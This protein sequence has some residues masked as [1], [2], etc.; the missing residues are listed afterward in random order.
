[1]N[2]EPLWLR[3]QGKAVRELLAHRLSPRSSQEAKTEW[4]EIVEGQHQLWEGVS[5]PYKH[6]IRA[7]LVHFHTQILRASSERF[8]FRNGS[9]GQLV[10]SQ[11]MVVLA[12]IFASLLESSSISVRV[13]EVAVHMWP[14]NSPSV[15]ALN[16]RADDSCKSKQ[17]MTSM[18]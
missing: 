14:S 4:Y 5:E 16:N 10:T 7:F 11:H 13:L 3:L 17:Q 8:S 1:M 15:Y 2:L 18:F 9:V 6:T 12:V